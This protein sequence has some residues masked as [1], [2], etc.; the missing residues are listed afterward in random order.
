MTRRRSAELDKKRQE[1]I[2]ERVR[3]EVERLRAEDAKKNGNAE[4]KPDDAEK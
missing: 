2:D 1:M 4:D 3:A